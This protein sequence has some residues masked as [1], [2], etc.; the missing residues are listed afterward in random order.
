[1]TQLPTTDLVVGWDPMGVTL[2][3]IPLEI[4]R[5]DTALIRTL[6]DSRVLGDVRSGDPAALQAV[7]EYYGFN[8]YNLKYPDA[9]EDSEP[10]SFDDLPGDQPFSVV[11]WFGDD[12][13]Y[14]QFP[15]ARLRTA[16]FAPR[17]LLDEFGKEDG[18]FGLDY[19][20]ATWF[21]TDDRDA[22]EARLRE[23]GHRVIDEATLYRYDF[24]DAREGH[25]WGS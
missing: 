1:M 3:V 15:L 6:V 7:R 24:V 23:L 14:K 9:D 8:E 20:P 11:Q 5:E 16:E 2:A 10:I 22:I 17:E 12:S 25:R 4:A 18:S 21:D 13:W 19:E